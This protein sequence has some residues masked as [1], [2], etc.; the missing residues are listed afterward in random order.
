V[1]GNGGFGGERRLNVARLGAGRNTSKIAE[2]V[3]QHL[4]LYLYLKGLIE[5]TKYYRQQINASYQYQELKKN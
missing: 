4:Y 1:Y 2:H 3:F 5:N